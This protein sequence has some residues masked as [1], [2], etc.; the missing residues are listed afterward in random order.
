MP[1]PAY[2]IPYT[3]VIN[4]PTVEID[5]PT[6]IALITHLATH[7]LRVVAASPG[8]P[9]HLTF[10]WYTQTDAQWDAFHAVVP[11]L[12]YVGRDTH[13][14]KHLFHVLFKDALQSRAAQQTVGE[15]LVRA[16]PTSD[17]ILKSYNPDSLPDTIV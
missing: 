13:G 9:A 2:P 4:L 7:N 17:V 10:H 16:L 8:H 12:T 1:R 6:M 14:L 11:Q 3:K 5:N 15:T